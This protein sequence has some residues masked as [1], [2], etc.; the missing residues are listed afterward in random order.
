MNMQNIH[1]S[2]DRLILELVASE[3]VSDQAQLHRLLA[4]RGH[5]LT[6]PTL[7]RHLKKLSVIKQEGRYQRVERAAGERPAYT[8]VEA[9][10]NLLVITTTPG[11]AQYLG[12]IVD[13]AGIEGVVGTLAGDDTVFIA[14]APGAS[15]AGIKPLV[16]TALDA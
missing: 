11:H 12:V 1:M 13:R 4:E 7:S 16:E 8:M 15:T 5:P 9:P 14:L 3:T 2:V 6:Q 10:P